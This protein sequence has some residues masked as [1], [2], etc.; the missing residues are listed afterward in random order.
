MGARSTA[1]S[2]VPHHHEC[3][4]SHPKLKL[5]N[6][7]LGP[8]FHLDSVMVFWPVN[9]FATPAMFSARVSNIIP[10]ELAPPRPLPPLPRLLL[11]LPP[12]AL[13][14]DRWMTKMFLLLTPLLLLLRPI[15]REPLGTKAAVR[16]RRAQAQ[17]RKEDAT[18]APPR[19]KETCAALR[20]RREGA[21]ESLTCNGRT[22][23]YHPRYRKNRGEQTQRAATREDFRGDR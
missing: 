1:M 7:S 3:L 15:S 20:R 19:R 12:P 23:K 2:E 5:N 11:P 8:P 21:E 18:M 14:D 17:R 9:R 16:P 6:R 13:H 10:S 22:Q 4:A